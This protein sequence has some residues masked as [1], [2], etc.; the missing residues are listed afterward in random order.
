MYVVCINNA[1]WKNLLTVGKKYKV[2][3]EDKGLYRIICD[4]GYD[5]WWWKY[6]F[7]L[8]PSSVEEQYNEAMQNL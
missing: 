8:L 4:A 7:E 6:Q 5:V 2:L 1:N 3:H